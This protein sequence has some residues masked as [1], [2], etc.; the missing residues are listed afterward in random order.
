MAPMDMAL[1]LM[2]MG[3]LKVH[4]LKT[5]K[6]PP[7]MAL[8]MVRDHLTMDNLLDRDNHRMRANLYPKVLL[9]IKE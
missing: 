4:Q 7:I 6:V 9:E 5:L 3:R 1:H 8:L 2:D